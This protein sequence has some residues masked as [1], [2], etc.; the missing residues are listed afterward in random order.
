MRGILIDPT[1]RTITECELE[2]KDLFDQLYKLMDCNMI[3]RFSLP[4][5]QNAKARSMNDMWLDEMGWLKSNT[6]SFMY[7]G[8]LFAGKCVLLGVNEDG[9]KS[10]D[11][12]L[13]LKIVNQLVTWH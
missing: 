7:G 11:T 1:T 3:E 9:T 12:K 6:E 5:H 2:Q 10:N 4:Y 8:V 13:K